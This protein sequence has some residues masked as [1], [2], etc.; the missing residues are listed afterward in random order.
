M[1]ARSPTNVYVIN[2][3]LLRTFCKFFLF[4][5]NS[6]KQCSRSQTFLCENSFDRKSSKVSHTLVRIHSFSVSNKTRMKFS[7][8]RLSGNKKYFRFLFIAFQIPY[9]FK[10]R[11]ITH[12]M[13]SLLP[14]FP[15]TRWPD[16]QQKSP[17]A[18]VIPIHTI[19]SW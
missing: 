2:L 8:S 16:P 13:R 14:R 12:P 5:V 11:V 17:C 3:D 7:A 1:L 10:K 18:Y 15:L 4:E 6:K 9:L 19:V